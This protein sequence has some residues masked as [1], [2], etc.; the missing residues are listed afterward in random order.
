MVLTFQWLIEYFGQLG[1]A[2]SL[3]CL[4]AM[5]QHSVAHNTQAVVLIAAKYNE[6]LTTKALIE[7]FESF[8]RYFQA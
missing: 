7:M 3:E 8:K 5:L 2:E 4:K 6:Q 1:V